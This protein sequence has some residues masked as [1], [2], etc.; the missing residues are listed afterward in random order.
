MLDQA[1]KALYAL[2]RK[3][4][5][6]AIPIDLQLKLFDSLITPILVYSCE[7]WGFE[8]KQGIEKMH[9]QYCKRILN[10]RSSTPNFM[11][12]GEIG[13]FPVEIIIKLR[14]ATFWNKML[15]N[16]NKLSSIMYRLMFKLH[17]SNPIHFK[18]ITYVKSIFDECGLSFIWN[19]QI[20]MNRNVLKSV[21]KQK[22]LDQYIQ[23][24]F[25]QINSSSRGE[26]YGIFKTEFKLEP[27]LIRLHPSDRIYMCKL[28]CS[29]LKLPIETGRW[30]NILKQ[31]RKCHLCNLEIGNEFHY[32][33]ICSYPQIN[34]LRTK[35]IPEYYLR[36]P[37]LYK[38]KGMLSLCNVTLYRKICGFIRKIIK[39]L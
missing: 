14:M 3:I 32:L 30:A 21:L 4:R 7:V 2:Y 19:D 20:H 25:Q 33:F 26:F 38:L 28:R 17:Q 37:S 11:V 27:Y 13:R 39:Y 5:N 8:N 18:W 6:L 12:Y 35:F 36:N 1:N 10:L 16:N 23:H 22:L 9:L 29:N 31:N 15:C 34:E 24:W